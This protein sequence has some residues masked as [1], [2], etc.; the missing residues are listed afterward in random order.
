MSGTSALDASR[1]HALP[2]VRANRGANTAGQAFRL[3]EGGLVDRARPLAFTFNGRAYTG[4]AGDTLASALIANGVHLVGRSFKYH[5]PRGILAAG[6]EEPGALVQLG[7]GATAIPNLQATTLPLTEGLEAR[8]VNVFP[9][10]GFDIGAVN[11]WFS[12]LLPAGF[13]YK[14]FFGSRWA[15]RHL[16]EPVIRRAAGWGR[17]PDGPDPDL[18][19]HRHRHCDVLVVGG[20]PAGLMAARA[21]AAG[22]ARVMLCEAD[23]R[24]GGSLL[25][26]DASVDGQ[27]GSVW[28]DSLAAELAA[29]PEVTVL[30][31]TTVFGAYDDNYLCAIEDVTDGPVRQRVWHLRAGRVVLATGAHE[32]P[33]VFA[34][35]DRPGVMLAGAVFEDVGQWKR[36]RHYP[37]AGETMV[38]AV[39]REC[40][41]VRRGVGILDASTL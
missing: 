33:L 41:A 10:V 13:Y 4:Y 37:A 36:P 17:A 25:G 5:R 27:P 39:A 9:S 16:Y 23:T 11:G 24:L 34:D 26:A 38:Q 18:Y 20:G 6:V 15:W 12:R 40:A 3:A 31:R 7:R 35:N 8:S 21:A 32:R 19:D 29:L 22:G 1:G 28:V 30:P 2:R 14:M